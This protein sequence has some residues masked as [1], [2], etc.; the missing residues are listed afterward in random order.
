ME[1]KGLS[2]GLIAIIVYHILSLIA[3]ITLQAISLAKNEEFLSWSMPDTSSCYD[4]SDVA[5]NGYPLGTQIVA[6]AFAD[7]VI[8]LPLVLAAITGLINQ[9]FYGA[10][11]SWMVFGIN[12][13]IAR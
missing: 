1:S 10:V 7:F 13:Y 12:I 2:I 5:V 3:W 9:E 11:G 4:I 8:L 6:V